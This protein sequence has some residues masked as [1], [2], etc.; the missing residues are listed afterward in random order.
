[1]GTSRTCRA[2]SQ[3]TRFGL[4]NLFS[5]MNAQTLWH[6]VCEAVTIGTT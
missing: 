6:R 1:M 3:Y 2:I 4:S 5:V